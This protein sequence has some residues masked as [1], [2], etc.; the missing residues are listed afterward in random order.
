MKKLIT[1]LA[2]FVSASAYAF[3]PMPDSVQTGRFVTAYTLNQFNLNPKSPAIPF[4]S[5]ITTGNIQLNRPGHQ[6]RL[7]LYRRNP[8][9]PKDAMCMMMMPAPVE[10]VLPI[11]N[12]VSG[13]CG[14]RIIVAEQDLRPVD[15]GLTSLQVVDESGDVCQ[16]KGGGVKRAD[17]DVILTEQPARSNETIVSKMSGL[18]VR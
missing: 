11:V 4:A 13:L 16:S 2:L 8:A 10:I 5:D 9:C 18:P 7:T 3:Q 6:L 12:V 14:G 17:V 15:G 1:A